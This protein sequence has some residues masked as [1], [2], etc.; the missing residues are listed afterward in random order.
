MDAPKKVYSS[1]D[2]FKVHPIMMGNNTPVEVTGKERI[3]LT[4][5]SF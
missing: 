3:E 4:N 5:K 2:A 1:L